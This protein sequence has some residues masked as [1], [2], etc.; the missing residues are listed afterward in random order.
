MFRKVASK[1]V[2]NNWTVI[3][4][5]LTL[6]LIFDDIVGDRLG[7]DQIF[8][9]L[10]I[11]IICLV[12]IVIKYNSM[13]IHNV[14]HKLMS[15]TKQCYRLLTVVV[16]MLRFE[17]R[18]RFIGNNKNCQCHCR[19]NIETF[20]REYKQEN[21]N[22]LNHIME[23]RALIQMVLAKLNSTPEKKA[24]LGPPMPPPPPPPLPSPPVLP[25]NSRGLCDSSKLQRFTNGFFRPAITVED[26]QNVKLKKIAY[27][28]GY[29]TNQSAVLCNSINTIK[30]KHIS[31]VSSLSCSTQ[32]AG[33]C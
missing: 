8:I 31:G 1:A 18:S 20:V 5:Y 17:E 2:E 29:Y 13:Y 3:N 33:R 23:N 19:A 28:K 4:S 26:I 30:L 15:K 6:V 14:L 10:A 27:H 9:A 12:V 11:I 25:A 16:R 22:I 21:E 32:E 7:N 24:L